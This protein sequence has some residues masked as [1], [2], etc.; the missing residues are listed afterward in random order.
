[1]KPEQ[2]QSLVTEPGLEA[3]PEEELEKGP[4]LLSV[5]PL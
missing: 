2:E 1:M 3:E 4:G 5:K